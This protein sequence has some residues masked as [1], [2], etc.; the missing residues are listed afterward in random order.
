[1]VL[2]TSFFIH[3]Q[4]GISSPRSHLKSELS[5]VIETDHFRLYFDSTN[6]DDHERAYWADRHEFHFNQIIDILEIDWPKDRYIESYIYE[7][8]WRKKELVG[9]KFT[10]YVPVWLDQD[11]MHIAKEHLDQVLKHE[12][13]HVLTK[14]FGNTL[15]NASWSIGLI[16]GVAEAIAKDAS[17]I[18][19]CV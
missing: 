11:Q 16:E 15:F 5:T 12:L 8:A 1:M 17:S 2:A 13:V 14:Q 3:P 7:N 4:L 18:S 9:A 10:S 6:F 19:T